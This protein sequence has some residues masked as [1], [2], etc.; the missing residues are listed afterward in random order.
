MTDT[1]QR[2]VEDNIPLP[3][4]VLKKYFN[5][6]NGLPFEYEDMVQV[7]NY[8]LCKAAKTFKPSNGFT[9]STYACHVIRTQ[10]RNEL[11]R[12][13]ADKRK[14]NNGNVS[15]DAVRSNELGDEY[16][17]HDV[18]AVN[19]TPPDEVFLQNMALREA[20]KTIIALPYGELLL[21]TLT[22]QVRQRDAG[23]II[24]ISQPTMSRRLDKCKKI[25]RDAIT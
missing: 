1:Q 19:E 11:R 15:L 8:A 12:Y 10:Y 6:G 14:A 2:L 9:F 17:F 25:L 24:G 7:G 18:L 16:T 20:L 4:F 5:N 3:R 22:K 23:R 13:F 21:H